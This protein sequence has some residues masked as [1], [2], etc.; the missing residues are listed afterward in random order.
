MW[1]V[2]Y[3]SSL[4]GLV[5]RASARAGEGGDPVNDDRVTFPHYG[6]RTA[7][8]RDTPD[9]PLAPDQ[10]CQRL[11]RWIDVGFSRFRAWITH[12]DRVIDR[13]PPWRRASDRPTSRV[14]ANP[15]VIR[16]KVKS[17]RRRHIGHKIR[18]IHS[19]SHCAELLL[20]VCW[21]YSYI[22]VQGSDVKS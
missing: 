22:I 17:R 1:N 5:C 7:F 20:S 14:H 13:E 3:V 2:A 12:P 4:W 16:A 19:S 10:G 8:L 21:R 18:A 11:D 9:T 15:F 6:R